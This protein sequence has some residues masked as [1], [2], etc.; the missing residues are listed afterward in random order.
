MINK[1][2]IIKIS[3]ITAALWLLLSFILS[4]FVKPGVPTHTLHTLIVGLALIVILNR[5]DIHELANSIESDEEVQ[6]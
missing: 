2:Q 5:L 3:Y 4:F 1:Y 6:K